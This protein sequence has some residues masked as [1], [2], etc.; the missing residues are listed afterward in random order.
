MKEAI[1]II[2]LLLFFEVKSKADEPPSWEPYR[3]VSE[4]G[5]FFA[6]V[7]FNDSDTIRSPWERKWA[8]SIFTKDS[9]ELWKQTVKATGYPEGILS[10]NGNYFSY[11]DYWYYSDLPVVEIYRK[12]KK[13]IRIK[14]ESFDI[15]ALFLQST[16]S[17][18]LWLGEEKY[19]YSNSAE[20]KLIINT[21]D[22][23]VWAIDLEGGELEKIDNTNMTYI[24]S[25]LFVLLFLLFL[26]SKKLGRKITPANN[27]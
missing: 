14:G 21:R 24:M 26:I 1:L 22:S 18:K 4:N 27:V 13:P 2:I 3:V 17:H 5:E 8:L 6:W 10:D 15:P 16:A 25:A 20:K 7:T 11:I 12:D 9:V 19:K 23:K